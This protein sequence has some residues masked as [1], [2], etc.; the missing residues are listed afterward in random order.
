M[1]PECYSCRSETLLFKWKQKTN[2]Y[3]EHE[4][5]RRLPTAEEMFTNSWTT[6]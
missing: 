6:S 2:D 5:A 1:I 3:M 4:D